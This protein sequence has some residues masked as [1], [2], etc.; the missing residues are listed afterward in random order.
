M[1]WWMVRSG[2]KM[3]ALGRGQTTAVT[4]LL[5]T[6]MDHSEYLRKYR[7]RWYSRWIHLWADA[8]WWNCVERTPESL[9]YVDHGRWF[10]RHGSGW[11][12]PR[13]VSGILFWKFSLNAYID[14]HS[15]P[16]GYWSVPIT[17]N[18]TNFT[19]SVA[20]YTPG[21]WPYLLSWYIDIQDSCH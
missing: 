14:L 21:A 9:E 4:Y 15:I 12:Q 3:F 19:T 13:S 5:S 18:D 20:P 1:K 2:G 10:Y 17:A 8:R 16:L 6:A 11:T 7:K